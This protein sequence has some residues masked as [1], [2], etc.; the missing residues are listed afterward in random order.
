M[1][2]I[3]ARNTFRDRYYASGKAGFVAADECS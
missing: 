2:E 1:V 3:L